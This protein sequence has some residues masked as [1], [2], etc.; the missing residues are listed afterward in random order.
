MWAKGWLTMRSRNG[1]SRTLLSQIGSP[2]NTGSDSPK[3]GP[4]P[5]KALGE[6]VYSLRC[7]SASRSQL[8]KRSIAKLLVITQRDGIHR[9]IIQIFFFEIERDHCVPIQIS[10]E[11]GF[12]Q[13]KSQPEATWYAPS[14]PV[15][16]NNALPG[17]NLVWEFLRGPSCGQQSRLPLTEIPGGGTEAARDRRR[18][19]VEERWVCRNGFSRIYVLVY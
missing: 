5:K 16:T 3:G 15:R 11:R 10:S 7:I 1:C 19:P 18:K 12:K 2:R 6:K 17:G 9:P 13:S 8:Q 4:G 14:P